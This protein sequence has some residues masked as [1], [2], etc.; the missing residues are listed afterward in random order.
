MATTQDFFP[1]I[2]SMNITNNKQDN[3]PATSIVT[4]TPCLNDCPA[5]SAFLVC[6]LAM[7]LPD[8]PAPYMDYAP[9]IPPNIH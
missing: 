9:I 7:N 6:T 8:S 4:P 1:H 2:M 3:I 5:L